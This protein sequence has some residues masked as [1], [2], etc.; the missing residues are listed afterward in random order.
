MR[1]VVTD[2]IC[3][4]RP[5]CLRVQHTKSLRA[6]PRRGMLAREVVVV[7]IPVLKMTKGGLEILGALVD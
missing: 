3:D 5:H 2:R 1:M 4:A 6:R 7:A